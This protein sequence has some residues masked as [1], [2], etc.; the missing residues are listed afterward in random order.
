MRSWMY[1]A[2]VTG[3]AILACAIVA[4]Q[5]A[6]PM[7][8]RVQGA[9]DAKKVLIANEG[10]EFK[11]AVL[12]QVVAGLQADGCTVV[13]TDLAG[14]ADPS[15]A[16]LDAVLILNECWA[17]QP[18]RQVRRFLGRSDR[19][20]RVVLLTTAGDPD[21]KHGKMGVDAVSSASEEAKVQP[22]ANDLLRRVRQR[23]KD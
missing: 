22:V 15:A 1:A 10:S 13:T 12:D 16:T 8:V 18:R 6:G 21:W 17:W 7:V 11:T 14:L 19:K 4:C 5:S 9:A 3:F 2:L 20:D 23:L